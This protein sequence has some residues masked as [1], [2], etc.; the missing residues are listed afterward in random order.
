MS[1][2][3]AEIARLTRRVRTEGR[4]TAFVALADALRRA[5]RHAEALQVLREGFRGFPDH[6]PA[7]VVLARVHLDMGNRGL[8]EEVLEDVIRLAPENLAAVSTLARLRIDDG[9][10]KDAAPLV[11]RLRAAAPDDP[12][13]ATFDLAPRVASGR[14]R[15]S[16]PFDAPALADRWARLGRYDRALAMWRRLA[17]A[18]PDDPEARERVGELERAMA[19]LGD[20]PGEP[21]LA[22]EGRRALPGLTDALDALV[23]EVERPRAVPPRLRAW[24]HL[25][26]RDA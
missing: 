13:V 22:E 21:P 19:G 26:W 25:F 11:A 7:R 1:A 18:A 12:A 23:D 4:S 5:D 20:A 14:P 9:R 15:T 3:D 6:G 24:S 17:A 10:F 16:D 2:L 8:A